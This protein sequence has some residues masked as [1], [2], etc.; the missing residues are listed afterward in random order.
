MLQ[1]TSRTYKDHLGRSIAGNMPIANQGDK[2]TYILN[3]ECYFGGTVSFNVSISA[4]VD[5]YQ[6]TMNGANWSDYGITAGD[7]VVFVDLKDAE[8][9]A[10]ISG[11]KT[12]SIVD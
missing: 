2:S 5:S 6:M 7:V 9:D 1:V 3:Y 10:T 12:V 11:S 8:E 4:S